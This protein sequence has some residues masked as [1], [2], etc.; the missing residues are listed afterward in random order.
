M[1]KGKGNEHS[2]KWYLNNRSTY[3]NNIV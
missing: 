1:L 2:L 3:S